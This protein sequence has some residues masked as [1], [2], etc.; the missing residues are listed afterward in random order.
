MLLDKGS[1][2]GMGLI[3]GILT[4]LVIFLP[5]S[6]FLIVLTLLAFLLSWE[7]ENILGVFLL[8]YFPPLVFLI[9]S[10]N[11]FLGILFT[12]L[13]SFF[14]AYFM[15]KIRKGIYDFFSFNAIIFA[16]VYIAIPLA[17]ILKIKSISP[18]LLLALIS[19]VWAHDIFAYYVGKNWGKTPF[20]KII[21]PKKTV[22]GFLAGVGMG[23]LLGFI[24][25]YIGKIHLSPF[26]WLFV[27][28]MV[29]FGDIFESFIKRNFNV[30]DSSNILG[31]HGGFLDRFDGLLMGALALAVF[32]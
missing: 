9:T 15:L 5:N 18:F 21:S 8:R 16:C 2:E 6:L 32:F 20:F 30:K 26:I 22:E 11:Y 19:T 4:L 7:L 14:Y 17:S 12:F 28:L 31:E 29:A 13:L 3:I 23:S 10:N 27:A 24:V 25:S 1:R